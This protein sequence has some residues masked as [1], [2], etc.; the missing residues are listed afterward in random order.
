MR[1]KHDP[2][3]LI[4]TH[5][6][7][8]LQLTCLAFF[9]LEDSPRARACLLALLK[10]QRPDG[11][12]PSPFDEA[13]WG[14]RETVRR[15][16]LMLEVG[17]PSDGVN[18]DLAVRFLLKQQRP[19]GGWSENPGLEIPSYA[20]EISNEQGVTWLT[21]DVVELLRRAG[22]KDSAECRAALEWLRAAQNADGGWHSFKGSMG[23]RRGTTGDPDS[24]AQ[25]TFLMG[26]VYG[27]DDPTYLKGRALYERFLDECV[28]DVERGYQIRPRDGRRVELDAYSLT[29]P[30]IAWPL[31]PPRRARA[32]FD[33]NE[34]RIRR[35]LEALVDIQREDGGW[36]PFW[37][38]E[39]SPRYTLLAVEA[40]VL[41]GAIA[42][43][44][45]RRNVDVYV[46]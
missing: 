27:H 25:I 31:E 17:M 28:R 7:E 37:E 22:R 20:V 46:T 3:P 33:A 39:S 35:I 19:D 12:F 16:H 8:A 40:L 23:D 21:A 32:G 30:L 5:G 11:G 4:F 9:D 6:E 14:T 15:A 44:D 41:S 29:Q 26:E 38:E 43:D 18:V 42:R 13:Q 10:Q 2:F 24:T 36:R 34:P 45:V 1:L